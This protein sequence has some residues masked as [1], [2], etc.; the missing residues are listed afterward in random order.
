MI[1]VFTQVDDHCLH[2]NV[3]PDEQIRV[4]FTGQVQ[5][6]FLIVQRTF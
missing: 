4:G 3:F 1:D 2:I 6:S 5:D